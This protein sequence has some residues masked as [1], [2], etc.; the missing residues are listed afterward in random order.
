MTSYV[1]KTPSESGVIN[2]DEIENKTWQFLYN[3]QFELIQTR[4]CDAYLSGLETLR[5][6]KHS[7][8]QLPAVN[9]ELYK[10]TGW[11]VQAV[12]ALIPFSTFFE[13]LANRKFPAAT[14]IRNPE[15]IDYLQEPDIFHEIFGHCPLLTDPVFAD[16]VHEYGKLGL[17]ASQVQRRYLAR[18]FWFTVEFG[19]IQQCNNNKI[20]GAGILSSP[21]ETVYSLESSKPDRILFDLKMALRTPYR[22]D[23]FQPVYFVIESFEEIYNAMDSSILQYIDEAIELG[24]FAPKYAQ[25]ADIIPIKA[26]NTK[27]HDC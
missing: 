22:I 17:S 13:L 9:R 19:L 3:R 6:S 18:I 2:Y 11:S 8:P 26:S 16:F 14:F 10:A 5:L 7:V 24:D 15:E 12:P 4:A 25:K 23:I 20:Y 21:G 1:A 27:A